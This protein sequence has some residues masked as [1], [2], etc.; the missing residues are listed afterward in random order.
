MIWRDG[1]VD[2]VLAIQHEV[3]SSV[4]STTQKGQY[5][6]GTCNPSTG[7]IETDRFLGLTDQTV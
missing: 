6:D 4:P 7:E 1:L 3:L 5:S 2:K